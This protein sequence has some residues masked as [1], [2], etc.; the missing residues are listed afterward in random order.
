MNKAFLFPLVVVGMNS[1]A[2]Y[3]MSQLIKPWVGRSLETHL[4]VV[5]ITCGWNKGLVYYLFSESY[6]FAEILR[7][8]AVLFV[9]WLVC[10]WLYRRRI[11]I[12]I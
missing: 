11:F 12:R 1:I 9:L 5:D 6:P 3:C 8:S 7:Y 2:M 4:S 10:L